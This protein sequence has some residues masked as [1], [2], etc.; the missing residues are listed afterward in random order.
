MNRTSTRNSDFPP[1][2]EQIC[3]FKYASYKATD[4][5]L[6]QFANGLEVESYVIIGEKLMA[7]VKYVGKD[8]DLL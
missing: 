5:D 6:R 7:E 4:E 1:L 3:S 8:R 2:G